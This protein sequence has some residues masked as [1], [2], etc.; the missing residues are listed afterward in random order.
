MIKDRQDDH[1]LDSDEPQSRGQPPGYDLLFRIRSARGIGLH[2]N[3]CRLRL[4]KSF[5]IWEGVWEDTGMEDN[6]TPSQEQ[7]SEHLAPLRLRDDNKPGMGLRMSYRDGE[8]YRRW[9]RTLMYGPAVARI[10]DN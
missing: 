6:Q 3:D 2:E 4:D 7:Y 8:S 10:E 9:S 1:D 5:D